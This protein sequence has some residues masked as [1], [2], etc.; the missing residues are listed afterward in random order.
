MPV[1]ESIPRSIHTAYI[2]GSIIRGAYIVQIVQY[3]NINIIT[4]NPN[5][6][7]T[8]LL[9]IPVCAVINL[10]KKSFILLKV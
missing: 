3:S 8:L 6:P 9:L 5:T 4:K 2:N 1:I 10:I 7:Q